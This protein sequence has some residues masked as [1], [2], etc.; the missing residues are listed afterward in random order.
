MKIFSKL[1]NDIKQ[2][3]RYFLL[4]L[5]LMLELSVIFLAVTISAPG[6]VAVI[7]SNVFTIIIVRLI[8]L[9]LPAK[10]KEEELE[11][12]PAQKREQ[13][14]K[15]I[16]L[17]NAELKRQNDMLSQTKSIFNQINFSRKLCF[18][19][20]TTMGY[21]VRE[22]TFSDLKKDEEL[23]GL[24]PA[25]PTSI[26]DSDSIRSGVLK[27]EPRTL[28][29]ISKVYS[30]FSIGIDLDNIRYA[31]VKGKYLLKGVE[32]K[33]MYNTTAE[34]QKDSA[35]D[36]D[37]CWVTSS[38]SGPDKKRTLRESHHY[39]NFKKEYRK[40]LQA[41]I[42]SSLQSDAEALCAHL[43]KGLH[44]N[45]KQRYPN[46]EFVSDA[47]AELLQDINWIAPGQSQDIKIESMMS[48]MYMGLDL[49]AR[50]NF[51]KAISE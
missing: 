5:L 36:V 41:D 34:L 49:I 13:E 38:S 51:T 26:T 22:E 42:D 1:G 25:M 30:K 43:T 23:K 27:N 48:D 8:I 6:W 40:K 35:N 28:L 24:I 47:Q 12:S 7:F 29:N 4:F 21:V 18:L 45:L 9:L 19:D 14:L 33:V 10:G 50:S 15:E 20:K 31:V 3:F 37:I 17:E 44:E 32:V 16:S 46:I 39:D 11:L 2:A